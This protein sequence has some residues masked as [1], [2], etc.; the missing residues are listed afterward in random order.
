MRG[1]VDGFFPD[2]RLHYVAMPSPRNHPPSLSGA[3]KQ[4]AS[5]AESGHEPTW[6]VVIVLAL[7]VVVCDGLARWRQFNRWT[8]AAVFSAVDGG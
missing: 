6:Q 3:G 7:S 4:G 2:M 8:R 1:A 5:A